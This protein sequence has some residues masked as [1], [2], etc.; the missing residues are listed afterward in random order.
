MRIFFDGKNDVKK[1]GVENDNEMGAWNGLMDVIF[2][3]EMVSEDEWWGDG[4]IW[5]YDMMGQR[6]LLEP[7]PRH[8][9]TIGYLFSQEKYKAFRQ[10]GDRLINMVFVVSWEKWYD[11]VKKVE[12]ESVYHAYVI[13]G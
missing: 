8:L 11:S 6:A 9:T 13:S 7:P 10:I 2:F 3:G 1:N 5:C 4:E 12:E